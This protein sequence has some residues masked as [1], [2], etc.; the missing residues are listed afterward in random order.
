MAI[1]AARFKGGMPFNFLIALSCS[2]FLAIVLNARTA[3]NRK[4][5]ETKQRP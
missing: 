2:G 3:P 5:R 4:S 1:R